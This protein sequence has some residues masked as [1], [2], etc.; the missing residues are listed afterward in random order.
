[1]AGPRL[2][3][4]ARDRAGL[5][6]EARDRYGREGGVEVVMDRRVRERRRRGGVRV[7]ERR[8]VERRVRR[9]VEAQLR[10]AGYATVSE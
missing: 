1:M 5:Y 10:S 3:I 4:V 8:R 2:L 7:L 6:V 9:D